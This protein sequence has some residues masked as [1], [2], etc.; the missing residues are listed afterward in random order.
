MIE[1]NRCT[2]SIQSHIDSIQLAPY[3]I[4]QTLNVR[5]I[6]LHSGE[7]NVNR[8]RYIKKD[9]SKVNQL[10][11]IGFGIIKDV[12]LSSIVHWYEDSMKAIWHPLRQC[13]FCNWLAA[14]LPCINNM[15]L[16]RQHI[17]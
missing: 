4:F 8:M 5:K 13:Y 15:N 11:S 6:K 2:S 7:I 16:S 12:T 3:K 9:D 14:K 17:S 1:L 10:T